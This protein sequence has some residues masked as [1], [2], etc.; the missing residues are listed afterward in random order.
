MR[1]AA[2]RM[3]AYADA[4]LDAASE[5]AGPGSAGLRQPNNW[6]TESNSP[7]SR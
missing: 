1:L 5:D 4:E 3:T 2:R 7:G 6:R